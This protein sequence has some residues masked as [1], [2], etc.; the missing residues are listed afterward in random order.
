M[1]TVLR[2]VEA[3][4]LPIPVPGRRIQQIFLRILQGYVMLVLDVGQKFEEGL[5]P[6]IL[7][8]VS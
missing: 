1:K 4:A 6:G 7:N 3:S 5:F 8:A 2:A